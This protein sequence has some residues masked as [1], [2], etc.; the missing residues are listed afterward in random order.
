[1]SGKGRN[2]F[3]GVAHTDEDI[4]TIIDIVRVQC[5]GINPR[6]LDN[7]SDAEAT[8]HC[9]VPMAM[10]G[11]RC[12]F[13]L[14][15]QPEKAS[16]YSEMMVLECDQPLD[17]QRL[18]HAWEQVLTRHD[19]LRVTRFTASHQF[20]SATVKP[21]IPVLT[22]SQERQ[23]TDARQTMLAQPFD[24]SYGPFWRLQLVISPQ[25]CDVLICFSHLIVDGW[26]MGLVVSE[27]AEVYRALKVGEAATLPPVI[28]LMHLLAREAAKHA[29]TAALQE[30]AGSSATPLTQGSSAASHLS[31][32]CT[33]PE[34]VN[35]TRQSVMRISDPAHIGCR[36][37]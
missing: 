16:A 15:S 18:Q 4:R 33:L 1:M 26:S 27:L 14:E 19:A 12:A 23:R 34:T 21:L 13:M 24:L 22:V 9:A 2:R 29:E 6:R 3:L 30:A 17:H 20:V 32:C 31:T 37:I 25:G 28:P 11:R 35:Y 10:D 7:R 36:F 8:N 5:V